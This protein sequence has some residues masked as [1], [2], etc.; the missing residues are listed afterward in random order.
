MS[1][2]STAVRPGAGAVVDPV[3]PRPAERTVAVFARR[4]LQFAD[5]TALTI[6]VDGR[7]DDAPARLVACAG[8]RGAVARLAD[9]GLW[10]PA[11]PPGREPTCH[12]EAIATIEVARTGELRVSRP[13][14]P[15]GEPIGWLRILCRPDWTVDDRTHRVVSVLA[16]IAASFLRHDGSLG[17]D[18][19]PSDR[20]VVAAAILSELALTAN[21]YGEM[22]GGVNAATCTLVGA[23]KGGM[24]IWNQRNSYLQMLTGSFGVAAG[25]VASSQAA[26]SDP[27]SPAGQV[28]A[29]RETWFTNDALSERMAAFRD[30]MIG[31]GIRTYMILP[32]IL[33]GQ[34]IGVTH[35]ANKHSGFDEEDV[36]ALESVTPFVAATLKH[37]HGRLELKRKESLALV[38]SAAATSIAAGEPLAGFSSSLSQFCASLGAG[39]LSV[40]FVDGSP[41]IVVCPGEERPPMGD[42]F[43]ARGAQGGTAM[44]TRTRPPTAAGDISWDELH[45][46]ILVAGRW[47]G[48]LSILRTPSE[49]FSEYER[50]AVVRLTNILALAWATERYQQERAQ[51]A[52]MRE[53]QRI[54][55]DLHDHVAQ[56]LFSA[57]LTLETVLEELEDEAVLTPVTRARDLLSRSEVG[58]R[59]VINRL[60]SP[61]PADLA[62]QLTATVQSVEED[63]EVPIHLELPP[64]PGDGAGQLPRPATDAVLG[65]VR[66]ALVNAAKHAGRCRISVALKTASDDRLRVLVADDGIGTASP[67]PGYGLQAH[68]RRIRA[69]GG[70][71]RVGKGSHGGT[72]VLISMPLPAPH[73]PP[74]N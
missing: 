54:A 47:E 52:R 8:A 6:A 68:R 43:L 15:Q 62:S 45:A 27:N 67:G 38:V 12:P 1:V 22:V 39:L 26:P 70:I 11:P 44:R 23:A 58:I 14:A 74:A 57:Q 37:V 31:F 30:F 24:A 46:P 61:A 33:N 20:A 36:R 3:P 71:L 7:G 56:I 21:S 13:L 50:A 73:R 49:P 32:L 69:H 18:P 34:I 60:S 55:D 29:R 51:M 66:E 5:G 17:P 72:R 53:R 65:A 35:V 40:S 41:Q 4:A 63:F 2:G 19:S 10:S 25:F 9:D 42:Q 28:V 64:Q 59:E 16:E 48:T